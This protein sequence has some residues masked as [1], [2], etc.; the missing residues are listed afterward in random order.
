MFRVMTKSCLNAIF[1]SVCNLQLA[2][3]E[4][5]FSTRYSFA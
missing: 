5:P 4:G 3:G 1:E 2:G